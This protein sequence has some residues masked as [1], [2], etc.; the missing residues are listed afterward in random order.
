MQASEP[1][2]GRDFAEWARPSLL[3]M[4]RLAK[5]LAPDAEPDDV[6]QDALH[7]HYYV[8]LTVDETAVVM[9]CSAGT[10]KSTLFDA[11][12]R[13]RTLLGDDDD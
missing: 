10:V 12:R 9:D 13:L 2:L 4:S 6:V 3:A 5:R 1:G 11:R 7:L 8:G